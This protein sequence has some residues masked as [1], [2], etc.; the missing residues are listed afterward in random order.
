M[1]KE[2]P[3]NQPLRNKFPWVFFI[4][5]VSLSIPFWLAGALI[6]K[7]LPDIPVNI[8]FSSLMA[9]APPIA[10][11]ICI[12]REKGIGSGK[13]LLK[14]AFDF[15][16]IHPKIWYLPILFLMPT[17][18]FIQNGIMKLLHRQ[19]LPIQ[20]SVGSLLVFL[21][22][23]YIEALAEE[24]GWQG[25]A[26]GRLQQRWSALT[27]SVFLGVIWALW[28]VIPFIQMQQTQTW[29]IWQCLNIT[30][31]RVVITWIANNTQK[32]VSSAVLYHT[33]N[34]VST[35]LFPIYNPLIVT[36]VLISIAGIATMVWGP[37]S[38]A[39]YKFSAVE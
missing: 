27:A 24:I 19:V 12:R 9:V 38:L 30:A 29:I 37:G 18:M 13:D 25:Y 11:V 39:E 7:L 32:S 3:L 31:T 15:K 35:M 17:V 28:H 16:D 22:I 34:N 6:P 23:F 10:A 21:V 36:L 14:R 4:L 5:V 33:M 1:M 8:P 2:Q 26:I 20:L